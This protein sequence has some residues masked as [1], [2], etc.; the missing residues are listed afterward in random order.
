MTI[1]L[2]DVGT[3]LNQRSCTKYW[4]LSRSMNF[5]LTFTKNK[6]KMINSLQH[7]YGCPTTLPFLTGNCNFWSPSH[8]ACAV[9]T[10]SRVLVS[11]FVQYEFSSAR[12]SHC[13][14]EERVYQRLRHNESVPSCLNSSAGNFDGHLENRVSVVR[15]ITPDLLSCHHISRWT[16]LNNLVHYRRDADAGTRALSL[17]NGFSAQAKIHTERT[18]I[19]GLHF[20]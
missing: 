1:V 20:T 18:L 5:R 6:P 10:L 9:L 8:C 15:W 2:S 11:M 19:P 7:R 13:S 14:G 3:V 12:K 17:D 16:V 4:F